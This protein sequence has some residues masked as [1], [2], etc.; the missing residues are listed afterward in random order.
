MILVVVLKNTK[1][2]ETGRIDQ[3][4]RGLYYRPLLKK[5]VY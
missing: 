1:K 5:Y 3:N 2:V 4:K